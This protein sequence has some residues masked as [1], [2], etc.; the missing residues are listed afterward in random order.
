MRQEEGGGEVRRREGE[1]REKERQLVL[2]F[3]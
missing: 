3:C 2:T 1:R